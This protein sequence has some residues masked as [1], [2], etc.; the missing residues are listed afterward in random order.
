MHALSTNCV[1]HWKAIKRHGF[2]I[3]QQKFFLSPFLVWYQKYIKLMYLVQFCVLDLLF[4][5]IYYDTKMNGG[6]QNCDNLNYAYIVNNPI[7]LFNISI[8]IL[9]ISSVTMLISL[10]I[11]V[12]VEV[13]CVVVGIVALLVSIALVVVR[14]V[15]VD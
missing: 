12:V 15:D 8:N 13:G 10:T 7:I 4:Q 5:F 9:V 6:P 14:E 2:A 3:W 1:N 11:S